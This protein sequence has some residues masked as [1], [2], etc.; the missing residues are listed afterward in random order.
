M[1][2]NVLKYHTSQPNIVT[3]CFLYGCWAGRCHQ[4]GGENPISA[5]N[6]CFAKVGEIIDLETHITS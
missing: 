2:R 3:V 6:G 5:L 1:D 4:F